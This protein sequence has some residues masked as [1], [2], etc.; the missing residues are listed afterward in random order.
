MPSL[1]AC[2]RKGMLT[3]VFFCPHNFY[4]AISSLFACLSEI[5]RGS[6]ELFI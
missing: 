5:I 6:Y 1:S 3:N 4:I 2:P